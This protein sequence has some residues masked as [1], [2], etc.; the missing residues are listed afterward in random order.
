MRRTF[1][2]EEVDDLVRD[3]VTDL[4]RMAFGHAFAR[5]KVICRRH[6]DPNTPEKAT[7]CKESSSPSTRPR[8]KNEAGQVLV[9][10]QLL[11]AGTDIGSVDRQA[12]AGA[13]GCSEA[14]LVEHTLHHGL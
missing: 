6:L 11:D 1:A 12:L 8:L 3:P 9:L 2:E 13:V 14:D 4:V 10:R 5:E 7:P